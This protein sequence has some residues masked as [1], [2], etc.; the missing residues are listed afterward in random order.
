MNIDDGLDWWRLNH[1]AFPRVATLAR[2][3]MLHIALIIQ[4]LMSAVQKYLPVQATSTPCERLFSK[5][6]R[7]ATWERSRLSN[8]TIEHIML[9]FGSAQGRK[10]RNS[11]S[12]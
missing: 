9:V 1:S 2:V 8:D 6:G 3:R 4:L 12:V 10:T 5:A 7:V 11:M